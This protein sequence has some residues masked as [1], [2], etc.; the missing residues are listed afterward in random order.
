MRPQL[1][2]GLLGNPKPVVI[3]TGSPFV[4]EALRS[5]TAE[6]D[7]ELSAAS[8]GEQSAGLRVVGAKSYKLW[9]CLGGL[10]RLED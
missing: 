6:H 7:V 1:W 3:F 4:S 9:W 10:M 2:Y 8:I 5:V